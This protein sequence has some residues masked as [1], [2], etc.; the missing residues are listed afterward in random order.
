MLRVGDKWGLDP[1]GLKSV[2]S[3][4]AAINDLLAHRSY[5]EPVRLGS[6]MTNVNTTASCY[7][8]WQDFHQAWKTVLIQTRIVASNVQLF[9]L[10]S[11]WNI[12][13][14]TLGYKYPG[15][16]NCIECRAQLPATTIWQAK[17]S[18]ILPHK[19]Q[20]L[21]LYMVKAPY[22]GYVTTEGETWQH[23][24]HQ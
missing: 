23:H 11:I 4:T 5:S 24:Q 7:K 20:S 6:S 1:L 12:E 2:K 17:I 8:W 10:Y 15:V 21:G 9:V 16:C 14:L 18:P 19:V 3:R 22:Y 13:A